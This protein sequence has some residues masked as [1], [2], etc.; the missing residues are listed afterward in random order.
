MSQHAKKEE[1]EER[2][3]DLSKK[4][5]EN[6]G[7]AFH[8]TL[9]EFAGIINPKNRKAE[10][11]RTDGIPIYEAFKIVCKAVKIKPVDEKSLAE[12]TADD[13]DLDYLIR[14]SQINGREILL[15]DPWWEK[16]NGPMLGFFEEGGR[17][18]AL[19]PHNPSSYI[20]YDVTKGEE[21]IVTQEIAY[22]LK[23]H[24]IMLYRPFPN[25]KLNIMDMLKFAMA[26]T[27]K[28]DSVFVLT[29]ALIGALLGLIVPKITQ[30]LFDVYIPAREADQLVQ[31]GL[32]LIAFLI[33]KSLFSLCQSIVT[34]R[35]EGKM[36]LTLQSAVWDRLLG[37]PAGFFREYTSGELGMRA[38]GIS[39]IREAIS[40]AVSTTLL[41][42]VFSILYLFQVFGYG[43]KLAVYAIVMMVILMVF[44]YLMGKWQLKFEKDYLE[45]TNKTSGLILQLFGAIAKFRVSASE[46]RA[47]NQWAKLFSKSRK[48]N[49]RKETITTII[50]TTTTV[51][52]LVFNMVFYIV[53]V[54]KGM[55]IQTGQFLAFIAAFGSFSGAMMSIIQMILQLNVIKPTY[56]MCKPILQTLPE[57]DDVKEDPGTL[58][59]DI[60]IENI[61]FRYDEDGPLILDNIDIQIKNGEYIAIVGPSGSGKSTLFRLLLGFEHAE[62]GQIYYNDKDLA[63]VNIKEVR[64]QLG[65]VIQNAQLMAGDIYSN[66]IGANTKLTMEDV[67]RAIKMAGMEDDIADMPM[68]LHTV[69]SG[70]AGTI[71]GGQRQRLLIARAIVNQPKILF[72]DEATS[73]LDNK[74]QKIVQD[75][76]DGLKST[77]VVIAHRLSTIINCDRIIVIDKG[78]I[79][80]EG[81]YDELMEKGGVFFQMAQRQMA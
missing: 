18:A 35:L 27:W 46:T 21:Y 69:L 81:N 45:T 10:D 9:N 25:K 23:P 20:L 70:G 75:S 63:T 19:I 24:G 80:E 58:T 49:F 41:S 67:E 12:K 40:G 64:R 31:V 28:R 52:P 16:D 56:E 48:I 32:M 6:D 57:Y 68:G 60:A 2:L 17:P 29:V 44:S 47:F 38:F 30:Q 74:T 14:M 13:V 43:K 33:G 11:V 65:V 54:K 78:K 50:T 62:A 36:D 51:M 77:R 4:R 34:Q 72:F 26:G 3:V 7:W 8:K 66:I 71:S 5:E 61:S 22:Q 39:Q 1:F 55:E 79:V 73:A 37:L 42:S 59:G 76:L 53:A 15:T